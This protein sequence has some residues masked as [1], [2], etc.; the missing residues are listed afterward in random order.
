MFVVKGHKSL[1]GEQ[2]DT[3]MLEMG[4]YMLAYNALVVTKM[5]GVFLFEL[6]KNGAI[7]D[8][9]SPVRNTDIKSLSGVNDDICQKG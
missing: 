3:E 1:D 9:T 6:L 2:T 8:N 4:N 7:D 5:T